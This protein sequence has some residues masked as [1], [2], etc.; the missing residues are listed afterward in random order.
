MK[1]SEENCNVSFE[2]NPNA[3]NSEE[4]NNLKK[5]YLCLLLK[6]T[7][8]SLDKIFMKSLLIHKFNCFNLVKEYQ[9]SKSLNK[10]KGCII[11]NKIKNSLI[12]LLGYN[13][14]F[15]MRSIHRC[16]S[17]WWERTKINIKMSKYRAELEQSALKKIEKETKV[18][19]QKL[20]EREKENQEIKKL[21]SKNLELSTDL[22]K[23]IKDYEEK[24]SKNN[25]LLK[26]LEVDYS[27]YF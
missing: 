1:T 11:S 13:R 27:N 2:N 26:K 22:T 8:N 15:V 4:T 16:L 17:K 20:K 25:I 14:E 23:K 18:Q 19:D 21:I 9:I 10:L 24:E 6:T 7:F 12:K 3:E 5:H